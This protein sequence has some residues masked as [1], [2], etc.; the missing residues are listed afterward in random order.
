MNPRYFRAFY[1]H[2]CAFYEKR[3]FINQPLFTILNIKEFDMPDVMTHP[4]L[5]NIKHLTKYYISSQLNR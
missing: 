1:I 2:V 5:Q 4:D 3:V